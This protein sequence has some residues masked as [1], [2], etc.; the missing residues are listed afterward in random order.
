MGAAGHRDSGERGASS[1]RFPA[2]R[3][4]EHEDQAIAAS[5]APA[6]APGSQG[7]R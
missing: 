5:G 4:S 1:I 7:E 3:S 2:W 6:G